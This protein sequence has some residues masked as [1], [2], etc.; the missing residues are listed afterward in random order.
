M[1]ETEDITMQVKMNS[2]CFPDIEKLARGEHAEESQ[3]LE[4]VDFINRRLDCADFR[5]ICILRSLYDFEALISEET[6]NAMK[7]C[8]LG[9]KYWMDEPGEDSMCYWSEN[10]Q[11]L[12]A[13]CEYL[14]GQLYPEEV[15]TNNGM[16]GSEHMDAA[17][18]RIE[19]WLETRFAFGLIEWHS[20]TYYEEDIAPLSLFID[21]CE[22]EK[23]VERA[24]MLMD[25]LLL[26]MALH[27]FEGALCAS[28]GR[29]Y[30]EQKKDSARQDVLDI[31]EKAFGC[32]R[33][34]KFDYT[35][36]SADFILN[37]KYDLPPVLSQIAD[38]QSKQVVCTSMG[39]DLSEVHRTL[40][41]YD[42]E[43]IGHFLWAMEAFTNVESVQTT[44]ELF[45]R[46]HMKSNIFLKDLQMINIW[47]LRQ[48]HLLPLLVRIL[49]PVTQGVAIQRANTYT[50]KTKHYMLST[51]QEYHPGEFGDQQHIWQATLPGDISVFT[52][53][54]GAAAFTDNARNFSP[55]YWVGN[56]IN[57][58]GAQQE[59][60]VLLLY[61]LRRR[62]GFM[63]K[64]RQQFTHAWFP[65]EKFDRVIYSE[66]T[67]RLCAQKNNS[68]LALLSLKPMER[69]EENELVQYGDVTGWAC[70]VGSAEEYGSFEDFCKQA[71][72]AELKLTER[73][74]CLQ[75]V[76]KKLEI[77]Y[78]KG[79][80]VDGIRQ[81]TSYP[82][83]LAP[84]CEVER[85]PGEIRISRGG[86]SLFLDLKKGIR[87]EDGKECG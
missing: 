27:S 53:H 6:L 21:L 51:A 19:K 87:R 20:N 39:L 29:C 40:S 42:R 48:L 50:C 56:G 7:Q 36:L 22:D 13:V 16:T 18:P 10:H 38:D 14:A 70:M 3:I 57:P 1:N 64:Q 77:Q 78:R 37:R 60:V 46:Y 33:I 34:K 49:N 47:L 63:E 52:T 54:P 61:D 72:C 73:R 2:K 71:K 67:N 74:L 5:M 24:K 25:L 69:R 68:F 62:K 11:M 35:R 79:F 12:F 66:K 84:G 85:Q 82:R 41:A 32:G 83:L 75:L 8:V 55:S 15:F 17:R 45:N 58:H 81:D 4:I 86:N 31:L 44:M 23:L 9:F 65:F 43:D 80:Y 76:D 59:N 26:D 28:S 30:E